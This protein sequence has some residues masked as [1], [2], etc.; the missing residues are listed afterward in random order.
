MM[1]VYDY[2]IVGGHLNLERAER[3]KEALWKRPFTRRTTITRNVGP[4]KATWCLT[5]KCAGTFHSM[6]DIMRRNEDEGKWEGRKRCCIFHFVDSAFSPRWE[7]YRMSRA[8]AA[9]A[10]FKLYN[11]RCEASLRGRRQCTLSE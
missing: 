3:P 2:N 9:T 4:A 5:S 10:L 8:H 1:Y 7:K 6:I 11:H